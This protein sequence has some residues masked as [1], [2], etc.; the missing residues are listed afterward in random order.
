VEAMRNFDKLAVLRPKSPES[1][2][3]LLEIYQ[4]VDDAAALTKLRQ[5]VAAAQVDV[6]EET[7]L[8]KATL[9]GARDQKNASEHVRVVTFMRDHLGKLNG[10]KDAAARAIAELSLASALIDTAG[11]GAAVDLSQAVSLAANGQRDLPSH[12]ADVI[13]AEAYF[14]RGMHGVAGADPGFGSW[15]QAHQRHLEPL[16]MLGVAFGNP[17]FK[18]EL[19]GNADVR[20][21]ID[22]LAMAWQQLRLPS[23]KDWKL[24]DAAGNPAAQGMASAIKADEGYQQSVEIGRL[25]HPANPSMALQAIW[26]DEARGDTGAAAAIVR[27]LQG[28]GIE[29]PSI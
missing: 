12:P 2:E 27:Q 29:L 4:Y 26:A 6:E 22:M 7:A 16:M 3:T 23:S 9:S 5:R 10:P 8:T 24:L 15:L 21:G 18:T 11:D 19:L 14:F 13:L 20:K 28:L 25:L 17:A 1:Y